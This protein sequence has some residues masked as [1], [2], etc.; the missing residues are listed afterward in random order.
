[1][2]LMTMI[3]E[4]KIEDATFTSSNK[5]HNYWH[6]FVVILGFQQD[7]IAPKS[8]KPIHRGKEAKENEIILSQTC[9]LTSLHF[10]IPLHQ[11]KT[12]VYKQL[13]LGAVIFFQFGGGGGL[14]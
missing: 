7:A 9:F 13:Y 12:S 3:V 10:F 5:K 8:K 4:Y 14:Y 2:K 11:I 6:S 1:Q